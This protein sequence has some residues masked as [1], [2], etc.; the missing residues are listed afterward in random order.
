MNCII[1]NYIDIIKVKHTNLINY[2]SELK[3]RKINNIIV[4]LLN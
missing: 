2:V 1:V 3:S 4:T